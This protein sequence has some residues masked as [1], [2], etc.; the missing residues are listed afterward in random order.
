[1]MPF[2]KQFGVLTMLLLLSSCATMVNGTTEQI[3]V[4]SDPPGAVV[5]VDCGSAPLYGG[6]TPAVL[7][8]ERKAEPCFVTIAK[9]GYAEE[10]VELRR[11]ISRAA[12]GNKVPGVVA[13]TILAVIGVAADFSGFGR[14][15]G[16][17]IGV[18]FDGGMELGSAPG[19]AIDRRTGAGYKHVP[20]EVFV[21]LRVAEE[22]APQPQPQ[23][24]LNPAHL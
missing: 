18:A 11:E 20:G 4:K 1:M 12:K 17:V 2:M 10:R 3:P 7:N 24:R 15:D 19:E 9:E 6:L 14:I 23:G 8:L 16:D 22:A 21:K 13:G 5:T